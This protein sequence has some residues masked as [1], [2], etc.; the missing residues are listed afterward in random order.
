MATATYTKSGTKATTSAKLEPTIFGITEINQVL[1]HQAYTAYL[2]NGRSNLSVTKTRG[3]V[4]GSN[5]KPWRQKGTGRARVGSKRTPVWRG[6]G[7]VFGPTGLENYSHKINQKAKQTALRHAYSA[8][9]LDNNLKVIADINLKE[10]KTVELLN[11]LQKIE[12]NGKIL[13]I[14]DHITND[15][16]LASR[17]LG[18][19]KLVQAKYANVASVI[20][21]DSIIVTEP[22]LKIITDWLKTDIKVTKK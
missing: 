22:A 16:K 3:E 4:S 13:L 18:Q 19:V 8:A 7:I 2:A 15:L 11:L 21:A 9:N 10:A 17:N 12:A 20:D 5:K 6:G 14:T 1:L